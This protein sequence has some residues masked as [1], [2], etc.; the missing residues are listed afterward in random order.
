M[1][2]SVQSILWR[3][4]PEIFAST[5][6]RMQY[7]VSSHQESR[8]SQLM[9]HHHKWLSRKSR[10]SS[11]CHPDAFVCKKT[12]TTFSIPFLPPNKKN[13]KFNVTS[14]F[15]IKFYLFSTNRNNSEVLIYIGMLNECLE[16]YETSP[17][18]AKDQTSNKTGTSLCLLQYFLSLKF[19]IIDL[20][21]ILF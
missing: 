8:K 2:F 18:V 17:S 10:S 11:V 9:M 1:G 19:K 13:L 12:K 3:T 7:M 4:W 21:C 5:C 14:K 15:A 20:P 16:G 6:W